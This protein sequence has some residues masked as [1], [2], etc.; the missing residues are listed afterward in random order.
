MVKS[1]EK[2]D[3]QIEE[4]KNAVLYVSHIPYGFDD[5]AG[6]EFFSQFGKIKGLCYP[7]SKK[8]GRSKGFMFILFE[9]REIAEICAKSLHNYYFFNK[10]VKCVVLPEN[11]KIIYNRFKK[12][13]KKFKFVP[14]QT[15]FKNSFNKGETENKKIKKLKKLIENDRKKALRL[16]ELGIDYQF[17]RYEDLV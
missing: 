2:N 10:M 8:T 6:W 14:W 13:P 12:N 15:I 16:K 11:H 3:E 5:K 17:T 9:D 7:R 1:D 4:S